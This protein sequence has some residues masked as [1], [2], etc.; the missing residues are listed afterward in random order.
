MVTAAFDLYIPHKPL[1]VSKCKT[2]QTA[3]LCWLF[4]H[5]EKEIII[6]ILYYLCPAVLTLQQILQ[7]LNSTM[8]TWAC[9]CK[10]ASIC[11]QRASS[12][13]SS[14]SGRTPTIMLPLPVLSLIPAPKFSA[15]SSSISKQSSMHSSCSFVSRATPP[16]LPRLSPPHPIRRSFQKNIYLSAATLQS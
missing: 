8:R 3:S 4:C 16:H 5:V 11:P 12:A 10:A 15:G 9:D 13:Y 1:L 6:N 7:W 14:W 2:Q